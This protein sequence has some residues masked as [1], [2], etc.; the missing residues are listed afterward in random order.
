MIESNDP[1]TDDVFAFQ[2]AIYACAG[3]GEG[4]TVD[5]AYL[6]QLKESDR[7]GVPIDPPTVTAAR[8]R[9]N[10]LILGIVAGDFPAM[11]ASRRVASRRTPRPHSRAG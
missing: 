11:A 10:K 2:L 9:A 6:H 3:R 4:L 7:K 1:K 8:Q 5:A